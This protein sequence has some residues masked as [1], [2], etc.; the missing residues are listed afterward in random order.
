MTGAIYMVFHYCE[1]LSTNFWAEPVNAISN[2]AFFIAAG[3]LLARLIRARIRLHKAIDIIVLLGLL[4]SIGLGSFL[5][6]TLATAW[7]EWADIVPILV[8]ISLYLLSFL[9]R[10]ARFKSQRVFTVFLLYHVFNISLLMWLS[11]QTL[12]GSMF[13]LP[14]LVTLMLMGMYSKRIR[15]PSANHL[16]LAGVMFTLS[17]V[18]RTFDFAL[19]PIWPV[20][21]H[22]IWHILNAC[23]LYILT[24][25]LLFSNPQLEMQHRGD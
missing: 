24:L 7:T 13:Y 19:C 22:F 10:I 15:H 21:T 2:L 23:V 4:C 1:R 14:T 11:P 6:H 25:A 16:L 8:F 20:G 3:L 9:V 5:W 18:I 12:N 17:I